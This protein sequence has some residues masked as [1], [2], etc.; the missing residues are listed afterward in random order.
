MFYVSNEIMQV[1]GPHKVEWYVCIHK[2]GFVNMEKRRIIFLWFSF[3]SLH[4]TLP[5]NYSIQYYSTSD[6]NESKENM[7]LPPNDY[8]TEKQVY[9]SLLALN[10]PTERIYGK[11][12][13]QLWKARKDQSG[14]DYEMNI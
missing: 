2:T 10:H 12:L 4:F 13:Y 7:F 9:H 5:V 11:K 1:E 6:E 3:F 8:L 14:Q